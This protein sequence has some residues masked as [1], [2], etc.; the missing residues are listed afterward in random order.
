MGK[1]HHS[2]DMLFGWQ[3][4]LR[5]VDKMD[6]QTLG[7]CHLVSAKATQSFSKWGPNRATFSSMASNFMI[8]ACMKLCL[9]FYKTALGDRPINVLQIMRKNKK[10]D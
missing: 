2:R 7:C 10:K 1:L 6:V 3:R 5:F 4:T 8:D 9:C